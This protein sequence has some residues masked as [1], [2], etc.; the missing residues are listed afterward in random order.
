MHEK[1]KNTSYFLPEV[2]AH[3]KGVLTNKD[4][5]KTLYERLTLVEGETGETV[6]LIVSPN[7]VLGKTLLRSKNCHIPLVLLEFEGQWKKSIHSYYL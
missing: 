5:V 3:L 1:H 6:T 4:D 7:F 2:A